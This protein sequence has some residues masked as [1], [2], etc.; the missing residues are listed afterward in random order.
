M[1]SE[2]IFKFFNLL[3]IRITYDDFKLILHFSHL[4][5]MGN[6][7]LAQQSLITLR[8]HNLRDCFK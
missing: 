4:G 2:G 8:L 1:R 7:N 5:G 3:L 6:S